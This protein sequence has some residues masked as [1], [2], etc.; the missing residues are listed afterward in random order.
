MH[1]VIPSVKQPH[2]GENQAKPCVGQSVFSLNLPPWLR[3]M[4][5]LL[6]NPISPS[7][8]PLWTVT[9][10]PWKSKWIPLHLPRG[11]EEE[12]NQASSVKTA[13]TPHCS[14]LC[15]PAALCSSN[16]WHKPYPG[17]S[18]QCSGLPQPGSLLLPC[19]QTL[20]PLTVC[21]FFLSQ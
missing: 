6:Q 10:K 2:T 19:L 8:P 9:R 17:E 7:H 12:T 5:H 13:G 20:P 4:I 1:F 18:S 3:K 21:S 11:T 15:T 16:K 14:P